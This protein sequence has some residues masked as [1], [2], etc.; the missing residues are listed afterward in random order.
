MNK[1]D[2]NTNGGF[3]P[4]R[5]GEIMRHDFPA[6]IV[7]FLVALPLCM[8]IAIAS[9]LPPAAGLITGIIGG[10][11]VGS[12]AGAPLQVSGPAAGLTV[13]VF[14]IVQRSGVEV[15]AVAIVIAGGV[16]I[17][18]GLLGFGQWFR[19]VS[20]AVIRGMLSGIGVLI[21]ASQFHVMVDDSPRETGLRNLLSIPEAV[22]KGVVPIAE[23]THHWAAMVGLITIA[24]I[25]FWKPI[26]PRR[27]SVLPAP[28]VAIV[29]A[30][31]FASLTHAPVSRISLPDNLLTAIRWPTGPQLLGILDGQILLAGLA[32]AFVA[33]AETLLCAT[34]VDQMHRGPR[35]RYDRELVAQGVGN[36]LCGVLGALPMTG[37][38]VRSTANVHAGARTRMSTI[39]HGAWLVVFVFAFP[40]VLRMVP[41][42][43][44]AAIL[45][46]TGAK[47]IDWRAVRDLREYGRGEAAI[48]IATV[49]TI[50]IADLLTG[51]LVGVAIS[52][53]KLLYTFSHLEI[54]L[55]DKF[56]QNRTILHL[57]GAATF[58][59]LPKMAAVLDSVRPGAELHV[60]FERLDY[61]D[62]ACLDLLMNWQK[63]H[64]A[65]GGRLV[66]DWNYLTAKLHRE[67]MLGS[68]QLQLVAVPETAMQDAAAS[69]KDDREAVRVE[70]RTHDVPDDLIRDRSMET[71]MQAV[72]STPRP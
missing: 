57:R 25:I 35:T 40:S 19:A 41:T 6:S 13:M 66:I 33:S 20:P 50:V 30:T 32:L 61:I 29:F 34:A 37:V 8:G 62:H 21:L 67:E 9:G 59:R 51:V 63:Q 39:L 18:A 44:L 24:I 72:D 5:W 71:E 69:R 56:P 42:A 48:F 64:E 28:L 12:I 36:T 10:L 70:K 60:Q 2:N 3:P 52:V 17:T 45:V 4:L 1:Q 23:S 31:A 65:S 46:Y 14:E 47:L 53:L 11:V 26:A 15:L 54:K 68:G 27:L 22:W 7:V 49:S 38:I 55:E 16:Q 58:I 43:S